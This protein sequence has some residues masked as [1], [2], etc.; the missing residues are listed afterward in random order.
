MEGTKQRQQPL[1]SQEM[2]YWGK[3]L[4]ERLISEMDLRRKDVSSMSDQQLRVEAE[5]L[6]DPILSTLSEDIP[7]TVDATVLRKNVL[8]EAVPP[9]MLKEHKLF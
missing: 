4:H 7:D 3:I 5:N 1:V 8:D 9:S 2:S 6:L